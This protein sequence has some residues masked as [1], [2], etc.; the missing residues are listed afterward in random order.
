MKS[1]ILNPHMR[2]YL[3]QA[4]LNRE[5]DADTEAE[6]ELELL[7]D[8]ELADAA[9]G[10]T[11]LLLGLSDVQAPAVQ[12]PEP[13]PE[14][15]NIVV[16]PPRRK[17]RPWPALAAAASA[18]I[19]VSGS[20]GY[21]FKPAPTMHGGAQLAYIDKQRSQGDGI[22]ITLPKSGPLV[23]MVPVASV[24]PCVADIT[25]SQSGRSIRANAVPDDFGYAVV[26]L[27]MQALS[28]GA[29]SVEVA[30]AG[31][32]VGQYSVLVVR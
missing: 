23:L 17:S 3:L 12:A 21:F 29:A 16:S 28:P 9:A 11:G 14:P 19:L 18:L 15:E 30:C 7:A 20:L 1:E 8:P 4:Y 31:K 22:Q 6:F 25:I 27:A 32:S 13:K 26:V 24:G 2:N 5:L 10:D